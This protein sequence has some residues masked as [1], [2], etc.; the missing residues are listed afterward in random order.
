MA[1]IL[2]LPTVKASTQPVG[3]FFRLGDSGHRQLSDLHAEGR[4]SPQR[5]V[6]DASRLH[7]QRELIRALRASGAQIILDTK[8]AELAA[9]SRFSGFASGAPWSKCGSGRPLGQEH[10]APKASTDVIGRIARF[11]VDNSVDRVLAPTHWL[12][13]GVESDWFD[14][15]RRACAALRDELD[16]VGGSRI[17]IDYLLIVPHI[18]LDEIEQRGR[19]VGGLKDLPF[20]NLW[21][22][23]SGFGSD[24]RPLTTRRYINS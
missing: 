2:P 22:R 18:A 17:A 24:A 14:I 15:D 11:A 7:H 20:E 5:V 21:L 1:Q 19:F 13:T 10:F 4:F 8:A 6:V 9:P 3:H 16:K 12:A 23:A